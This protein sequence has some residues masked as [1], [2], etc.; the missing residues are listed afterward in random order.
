MTK[1]KKAECKDPIQSLAKDWWH[2]LPEPKPSMPSWSTFKD[3]LRA[4]RYDH[5]LN[6]K[7]SIAGTDADAELWFDQAL[8]QTWRN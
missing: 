4:N 6:F 2:G 5:Y 7:G 3:W 8:G 1:L